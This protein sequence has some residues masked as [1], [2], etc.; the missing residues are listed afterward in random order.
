MKRDNE[1]RFVEARQGDMLGV[2][3]QCEFCWF[4]NLKKRDALP[5]EPLDKLLLGYARRVNLDMMWSRERGTVNGWLSNIRKG[6]KMSEE[7]GLKPVDLKIEAWPVCDGQG[8]QVAIETLRA[9]QRPGRNDS[10]Y[11]QFD[12]IRKLR[13]AYSVVSENTVGA[14]GNHNLYK[15]EHGRTMVLSRN[16]TDSV[17]FRKFILGVEK[18]MGRLVLQ[19]IGISVDMLAIMLQGYEEE[20]QDELIDV[21]RKR[22][23]IICGCAFINLF[24]GALRGGE[25]LLMERTEFANK[26]DCGKFHPTEPHVLV[27][28]MGRFKGETGE[29]NLLLPFASVTSSGLEVRFWN[30]R[31]CKLLVEEG[32]D[33][34]VGP[35]YC[36]E[37]GTVARSWEMNGELTSALN[38]VQVLRPDLIHKQIDVEEKFNTY[39]SFRRGATT[40]AKVLKVPEEVIELNNRWNKLQNSG[41]GLS[42]LPMS[43]LYTEITQALPAKLRFSKSL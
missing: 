40:R 12:T 24:V 36:R 23:I 8:F 39:R 20:L 37:D 3:F 43:Q 4:G 27:P 17:L 16:E 6:K 38:R 1:R 30:E 2:P 35:A 33:K 28:L 22:K 29:R 25:V 41:G 13:T 18:R 11:T 26:I 19:N 14:S 34:D 42:K 15:G 21:K 31:L 5:D 9:S 7:L 10:T 32:K